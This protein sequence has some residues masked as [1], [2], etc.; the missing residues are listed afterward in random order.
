MNTLRMAFHGLWKAP[1]C[2]TPVCC[3]SSAAKCR[4][5][6]VLLVVGW[7][8]S[9]GLA[10]AGETAPSGHAAQKEVSPPGPEVALP[11]F[12]EVLHWDKKNL[13]VAFP[14][15]TMVV[16]QQEN[17]PDKCF[18]LVQATQKMELKSAQYHLADARGQPMARLAK[19]DVVVLVLGGKTIP[20]SLRRCLAPNAPI[21]YVPWIPDI[22]VPI[23]PLEP[24]PQ[25]LKSES[26][27]SSRN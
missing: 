17:S 14:T 10:C 3:V 21:V 2:G 4:S 15:W 18:R 26:A 12:A 24:K 7:W 16:L 6:G 13:Q 22:L 1:R 11:V 19:G 27:P 9:M 25:Q 23:V 20:D 8:G 5:L